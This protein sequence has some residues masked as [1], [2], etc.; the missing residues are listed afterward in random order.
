MIVGLGVD[1]C[2]CER[3]RQAIARHGERFVER[4]FTAD[5]RAY[6]MKMRDPVPHLAARFAAKEA[7]RKALADGPDLGWHEVEVVRE[8]AGPVALRFSGKAAEGVAARGV[9]RAHLSL[10]HERTVAVATVILE[11]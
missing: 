11:R 6:C 2:D 7:A 10:A 8:A 1:V 4:V 9:A 3:L 5:E